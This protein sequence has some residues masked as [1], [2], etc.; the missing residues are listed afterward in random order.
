MNM[1]KNTN[2]NNCE[3]LNLE[4][5]MHHQCMRGHVRV[6]RQNIETGETTLWS[7]K[8]NVIV[9]GGS[10]YV[11][12]KMLGLHLDSSHGVNYDDIGKDTSLVVPDLNNSG[13]YQLGVDPEHYSVMEDDISSKHFVQGFM[14]GNGGSGEDAITSKNTNYSFMALRNPIPFQQTQTELSSTIS[15]QYLGNLRVG[16]SSF[17]KSY[18]IKKFDNRPHIYHNW[19][20][21]GKRWDELDPVTQNDLGPNPINGA[22]KTD[23]IETY[24]DIHFSL[25]EDD[26]ISYF[27]HEGSNQTA[28]VNELG[29]VAYDNI[30]GTRSCV[31]EI[32]NKSIKRILTL[33]YDDKRNVNTADSELLTLCSSVHNT[34]K[35]LLYSYNNL[36]MNNFIDILALILTF[37]AGNIDYQTIQTKLNNVDDNIGVESYYNRN[38]VLVYLTDNFLTI[39]TESEFDGDAVN[40]IPGL[41]T[42]EAQRIKLVTYYTFNS[43][44][45]QSNYRIIIDYRIYAN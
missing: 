30:P 11:L 26:C 3:R 33:I 36:K 15:N 40:N 5:K 8:D 1:T 45:L 27:N 7:D 31:T 10:Q 24:A 43:I 18:Y 23:R 29:L 20:R 32:Y 28:M 38:G 35:P 25:N 9:L 21:D 4:D 6:F 41:T 44:P 12:M 42:D 16:S 34:I 2:I 37:T 13:V 39:L 22:G 17:S 14:I 19:W